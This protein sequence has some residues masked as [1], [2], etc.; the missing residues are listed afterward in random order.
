MSQ[1]A[2]HAIL[3]NG[4]GLPDCPACGE[5]LYVYLAIADTDTDGDSTLLCCHFCRDTTFFYVDDDLA[6]VAQT[7]SCAC[8]GTTYT[9]IIPKQEPA[10]ADES[11]IYGCDD[12]PAIFWLEGGEYVSH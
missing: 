9:H 6:V 11:T 3:D 10:L 12:C 7:P 2:L 5:N 1:V 4:L 8:C